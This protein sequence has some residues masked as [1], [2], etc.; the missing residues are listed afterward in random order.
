[1][2]ATSPVAAQAP[3]DI[4]AQA[5]QAHK[6][7]KLQEA[8]TQYERLLAAN[9]QHADALHLL[10][11]M[12]A[13]GGRFVEAARLMTQAAR[14]QPGEAL[15]HNNLGNVH[16][17]LGRADEAL[18]SCRRAHELAPDR[19]DVC[20]NLGVLLSRAGRA[21]EAEALLLHACERA[22]GFVDARHNLANHYLRHDQLQRAM[23]VCVD[24]MI[25]APR[26]PVL[27][28]VLGVVYSSLGRHDEAAALY[29][30]WL[31]EEPD[32]AEA[33]F[34]LVA[35]TQQGVPECA[36][37]RYVAEMFDT[38]AESFDAKLS[39]LSYHAPELVAAAVARHAGAAEGALRV[40]DAGCGTGLCGPLVRP[41]A[42]H[43]AGVDLSEGMLAKARARQ[44]YDELTAGELVSHI[45][46]RPASLELLISAD[47]LIYIGALQAF[48]AATHAA[49]LPAGLLVFTLEAH[50]DADDAPAY[51]LQGNG[52]YSHRRAYVE[53]VLAGAGFTLLELLAVVLR[54]E[55][56]KPV[57]G[58][59]VAARARLT[60][61]AA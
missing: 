56:R 44:V 10:G 15:F 12:E 11:L 61:L 14:L 38:F 20:N 40:L 60:R 17:E 43:L 8:R 13:Q 50:G 7:G 9:P 46:A 59:L 53:A 25:V 29:A 3:A 23:E 42:R 5:M 19:P 26:S 21:D 16:V 2:A 27:R 24:A 54:L 33:Q 47:T 34:R 41:W 6:A 48:A 51:R 57:D 22:P 52:R 39:S 37:E 45:A 32:N 28:R 49:L 1:M 18:A 30:A 31:A 4:L 35:S 55:A 58:W 36:P